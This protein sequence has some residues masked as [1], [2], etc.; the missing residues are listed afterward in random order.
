MT[1]EILF[2]EVANLFGDMQNMEYLRQSCPSAKFVGTRLTDEPYFAAHRPD[3]CGT[4]CGRVQ[5]LP[6]QILP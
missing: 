6:L 5:T 3:G 1:V 4:F 2:G